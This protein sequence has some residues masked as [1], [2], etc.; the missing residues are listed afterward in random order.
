MQTAELKEYL[1]M[2]VDLE[3]RSIHKIGWLQR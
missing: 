2:C 1:G 3:N